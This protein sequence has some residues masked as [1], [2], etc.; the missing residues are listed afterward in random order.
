MR[1]RP[2]T[3][4]ANFPE[5]CCVQE[6]VWLS[7]LT[8]Q[9]ALPKESQVQVC[10]Q[11][12]LA[13]AQGCMGGEGNNLGEKLGLRGGLAR[14]LGFLCLPWDVVERLTQRKLCNQLLVDALPPSAFPS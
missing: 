2:F 10:K 11:L 12:G 6:P 4:S 13:G 3:P 7:E 14:Q 5:T 8:S 9:R 1:G